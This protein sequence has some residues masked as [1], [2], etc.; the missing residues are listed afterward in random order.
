M[1]RYMQISVFAL[2][3][4]YIIVNFHRNIYLQDWKG[5]NNLI[6]WLKYASLKCGV[7]ISSNLIFTKNY[8]I[9]WKD[10][11]IRKAGGEKLIL[12]I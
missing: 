12:V 11:Q 7:S 4:K 2:Y 9:H 6:E 3:K 8:R 5:L 10:K 1:L